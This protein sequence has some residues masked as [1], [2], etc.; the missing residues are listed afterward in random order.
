MQI[1]VAGENALIIYFGEQTSPEVSAKVQQAVE[2]IRRDLHELIVDLVPSYASLLVIYDLMKTDHHH[3]RNHL[4][5][6]LS[7]LDNAHSAEGRLVTLPAYYSTESGPDLQQL[8][9][10][11]GLSVDEVIE[12]HQQQEYRVYAI[13]FAPGFAYLGEV[14]PRI[15]A[16]RLSTP[17][18]KVPRGAVAIADRQ[19]AVYPAESPG[20]WNLIGLCPTRMFNPD[21]DPTMP[22]QAGDRVRFEAISREQFIELGGELPEQPDPSEQLGGPLT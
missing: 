15:A 16:P 7:G 19:T 14:D 4:R 13:G 8:A 17:R 10:N 20:G 5:Q 12:I 9:D 22:V 6:S 18:L 21:A 1:S 2:I 11:A 3:V